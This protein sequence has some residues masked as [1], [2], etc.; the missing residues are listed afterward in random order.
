MD[1][2]ELPTLLHWIS[3]REAIRL[4]KESGEKKPWTTD[5]ILK[6]YR[7]CNVRRKDDKV[8]RWLES[9]WYDYWEHPNFIGAMTLSRL[10][11]EPNTLG[12]MGF[13]AYEWN[14]YAKVVKELRETGVR[15]FNPAYIVSTCGEKMDKV[16]YVFR[17]AQ[18]ANKIKPRMSESL[19]SYANRLMQVRG[20]GAGFL[21]AQVVADVKYTPL[22]NTTVAVDWHSWCLPGPGSKRGLNRLL[23]QD[24]EANWATPTFQKYVWELTKEVNSKLALQL[25]AQDVQNCLCEFDKYVR[26]KKGGRPKQTYPGGR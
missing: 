12:T 10:I 26:A 3:E 16:D 25:H 9:N 2:P 4:K 6:S 18:E 8:T 13:P 20:L 23:N 5:P 17:V 22:L 11:N 19:Q 15:I 24:L 1:F 14:D 7:F 21:A